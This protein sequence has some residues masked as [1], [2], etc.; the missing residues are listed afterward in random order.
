MTRVDGPKL[1]GPSRVDYNL[2][3]YSYG[4]M[5]RDV[6]LNRGMNFV[7]NRS[8]W[9]QPSQGIA[10]AVY[11]C[12]DGL[13]LNALGCEAVAEY[14]LRITHLPISSSTDETVSI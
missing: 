3:V 5:M 12:S 8:L 11:Y 4:Q 7:M 1:A 9:Y 14:W 2:M 13:H 6:L 10:H